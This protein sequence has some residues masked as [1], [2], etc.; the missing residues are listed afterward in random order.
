MY[1]PIAIAIIFLA[2]FVQAGTTIGTQ[3]IAQGTTFYGVFNGDGAGLTNVS[4][5]A[6]CT[7]GSGMDSVQCDGVGNDASGF[8]AVAI[9]GVS[10]VASMQYSWAIG[11]NAQADQPGC[12]IWNDSGIGVQTCR[13]VDLSYNVYTKNGAYFDTAYSTFTGNVSAGSFVGSGANLTGTVVSSQT[14]VTG[15]RALAT[16]YQNLTGR[17]LLVLVSV[18]FGGANENVQCDASAAPT[19]VVGSFGN[20]APGATDSIMFPVLPNFYYRIT[21][22]SGATLVHWT[23]WH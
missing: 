11:Q 5:S 1:K 13:G 10:N 14:V 23:E 21:N 4:G 22:T 16:V 2:T 12:Y 15:S 7:N 20:P 19:T 9:G 18:S 17:T 8:R 6:V 3:D